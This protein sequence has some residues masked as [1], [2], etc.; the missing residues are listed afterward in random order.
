MGKEAASQGGK[1]FH[2]VV[3][4]DKINCSVKTLTWFSSEEAVVVVKMFVGFN[5][6]ASSVM[7]LGALQIH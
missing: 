3:D 5:C 2:S 4:K 1:M 6:S 7:M